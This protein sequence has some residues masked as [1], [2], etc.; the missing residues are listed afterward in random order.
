MT[1][2]LTAVDALTEPTRRARIIEAD[3]EHDWFAVSE[4][5][6]KAE[7][8]RIV[9]ANK[10]R[11]EDGMEPV[12]VPEPVVFTGQ[13]WCPWCDQ[14]V[15]TIDRSMPATVTMRW[16]DD[17]L[18]DQLEEV[19]GNSLEASGGSK[20]PAERAPV[21]IGALQLS[22]DIRTEI[23]KW[24]RALGAKPG[25][26]LTLRELLRSWHALQLASSSESRISTLRYWANRI[27]GILQPQDHPEI[28]GICPAC[29]FAFVLTQDV[30][31]RALQGTNGIS[32]EETWVDCLVC[33]KQWKG[34]DE[35]HELENATRRLSGREER[36][37]EPLIG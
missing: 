23:T 22:I 34:W 36:E 11:A 27:R 30:R 6:S 5:T 20:P 29:E 1:D 31:M 12:P 3:H 37:S 16:E 14:V 8:R 35:L 2:L 19:V 26:G 18:L 25:A 4:V 9:K 17:P 28:L 7:I 15:V 24:L 13:W 33:G 10:R 32:Y 21:D